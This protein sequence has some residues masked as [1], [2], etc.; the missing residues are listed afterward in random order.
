MKERFEELLSSV[1][2]EGID[3]LLDFI[4]KSDFYTAPAST[5]FHGAKEGGLLEHSLN[6]W[7]C[8]DLKRSNN[9]I[10]RSHLTA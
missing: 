8:L 2:C 9:P 7:D 3:K 6:V 4:R 1:Q 10:G 5:R